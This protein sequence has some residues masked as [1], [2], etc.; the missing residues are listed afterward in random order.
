LGQQ[1]SDNAAYGPRAGSRSRRW[2]A[3]AVAVFLRH[4]KGQATEDPGGPTLGYALAISTMLLISPI[5]WLHYLTWLLPVV[6]ACLPY[7]SGRK[8]TVSLAVAALALLITQPVLIAILI[9]GPGLTAIVQAATLL[10]WL[11]TGAF[12]LRTGN[13]LIPVPLSW[14]AIP[15]VTIREASIK[16][17]PQLE[18]AIVWERLHLEAPRTP[19]EDFDHG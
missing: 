7:M 6:A 8:L 3:F 12:Y 15:G 9:L 11:L 1:G 19:A 14:S 5:V 4:R 13:L 10:C 2:L 17:E 18:P 16:R